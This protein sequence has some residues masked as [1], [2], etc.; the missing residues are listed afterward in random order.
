ME[1]PIKQLNYWNDSLDKMTSRL[2]QDSSRRRL[3]TY[4]STG[5]NTQL[6]YLEA[7]AALFQHKDLDPMASA[8]NV[9]EQGYHGEPLHQSDAITSKATSV[10]RTFKD[11][12]PER[13]TS[14]SKMGEQRNRSDHPPRP[15]PSSNVRVSS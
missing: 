15:D 13:L 12:D 3:R 5:D 11:K 14:A 2:A 10:G 9:I 6:Q 7:A 8:R 1:Q 4:L